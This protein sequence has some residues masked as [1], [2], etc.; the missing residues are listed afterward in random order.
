MARPNPC[1][2]ECVYCPTAAEAPKSYTAESPAVL[3]A[4]RC[5][6]D[7][8]RQV[9]QRVQSLRSMGH[10]VEKVELIIMGGTFLA[11]PLDYQ[12]CFVKACYDALNGQPSSDLKSA[13]ALNES[14]AL[15]C[16]GLC[17]ETRPD[18]CGE[19]EI[20][21]LHQYGATRVELGVQ[22]LDDR[23]HQLTRRGHGVA[24][25]IDATARLRRHGFKVYYHWMPGLPGSTPELDLA[26]TRRLFDD[27][28]FRPDGLKL[29][30]T[31]VVHGSQLEQWYKEG[32]FNP[33]SITA[34]TDLLVQVKALVPPYVRIA[35]LMRDIPPKYIVAGCDDLALRSRVQER[36]KELGLNCSCIRCRE[37]GHR[38]RDGWRAGEPALVHRSYAVDG[39]TEVMLSYEDTADTLYGLLRLS[40]MRA[41]GIGDGSA[42]V[43]A[44]V[45]EL[46]V[47]GR[48]MSLGERDSSAAQHRGLGAALLREAERVAAEHYGAR[49]LGVLSGVGV[50]EYYRNLGYTAAEPYMVKS[51]P[52]AVA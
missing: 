15:R 26:L 51:L 34:M 38:L 11:Y 46:H 13:K 36:M 40:I 9:Q 37:Y 21:L 47:F 39:G 16:V 45:R 33:V 52:A 19:P 3:R 42:T 22:T 28:A 43:T 41:N 6:F 12:W 2:G 4:L 5:D 50:R 48:E 49:E 10:P 32:R 31:V 29:Y 8:Y 30:P 24:A 35:R 25:I 20:E 18:W 1:P 23:I 7:P 27:P 17:V 44:T 14:A